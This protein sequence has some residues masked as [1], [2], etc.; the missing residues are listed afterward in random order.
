MWHRQVG[1]DI[2]ELVLYAGNDV[3]NR[4]GQST[5]G[6]REA[7]QRVQLV[8]VT[9]RLDARVRLGHAAHIAEVG[10][11]TVAELGVDAGEVH[12]HRENAGYRDTR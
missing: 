11:T 3:A 9:V 2:E 12:G 6:D 8:Y 10:L 5:H 7:E 4:I 1:A